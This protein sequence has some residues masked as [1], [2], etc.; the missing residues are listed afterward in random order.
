MDAEPA[1]ILSQ[2]GLGTV[3][4]GFVPVGRFEGGRFNCMEN[5]KYTC[6]K[7]H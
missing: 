3:F 5:E 6:S 2:E 7:L 4:I 1:A